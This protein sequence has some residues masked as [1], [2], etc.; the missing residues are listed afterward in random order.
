MVRELL[1]LLCIVYNEIVMACAGI[2][3]KRKIIEYVSGV[4]DNLVITL[5]G[6]LLHVCA[7]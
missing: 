5:Q 6:E 1:Q 4:Y 3:G 2:I 7:L